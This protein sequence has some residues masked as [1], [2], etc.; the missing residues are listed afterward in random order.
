MNE[1]LSIDNLTKK[2]KNKIALDDFSMKIMPG[3]IVAL[4]GENGAGKTTLLNSICGFIRPTSGSISF[5][6]ISSE[7][8]KTLD[9]IGVLIE[10]SFLDYLTA[11]ENLQYLSILSEDKKNSTLIESLLQKTELSDSKKKKVKTFSFGMKQR[12]GLCQSLLTDVEL[13]IFDEPFVGLDPVGKELFKK[14]ILD[15]AHQEK[16]P[17]L[18]SSHDLDDVEEVCDR[19]VM[20]RKGKKVLDQKLV[21]EKTFIL[22]I[23]GNISTEEKKKLELQDPT[24]LCEKDCIFFKNEKNIV[25]IQRILL[26]EGHYIVGMSIQN[27]NLKKLFLAEETI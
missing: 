8:E 14:V 9:K 19:V 23:D 4:I 12:L 7:K 22:K 24:I 26:Q 21:R 25:D 18:F 5:K 17:V 15:K 2:Y 6:G 16:I 1:A 10:P 11:E 3:E 27:N 13:L 20:V